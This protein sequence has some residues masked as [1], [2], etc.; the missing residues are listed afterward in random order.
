MLFITKLNVVN[1]LKILSIFLSINVI[2]ILSKKYKISA[3][4]NLVYIVFIVLA[5]FLG[6]ILNFY[7]RVIYY[8]KFIHF[9]FGII[10]SYIMIGFIKPYKSIIYVTFLATLWEIYEYIVSIIFKIDPQNNI[11]TGVNDTMLDLI[12]ALIGASIVTI[13][14]SC[15]YKR[16]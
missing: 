16:L 2:N 15:K 8:D 13:I 1:T 14:Y 9:L 7:D 12:V 6:V 11:T 10:A 4:T 5:H 3:K